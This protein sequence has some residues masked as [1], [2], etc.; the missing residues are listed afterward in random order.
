MSIMDDTSNNEDN[1]SFVNAGNDGD[2]I[3]Q[4]PE[5]QKI[6]NLDPQAPKK[7][8]KLTTRQY[9][10][11]HHMRMLWNGLRSIYVDYSLRTWTEALKNLEAEKHFKKLDSRAAP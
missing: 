4:T 11:D 3:I 1:D 8:R 6:P 5:K 9:P 10:L 2:S 7:K